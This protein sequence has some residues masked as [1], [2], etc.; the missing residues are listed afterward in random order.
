MYAHVNTPPKPPSEN[1]SN[2]GTRY[3]AICL[4]A[5]AKD[6][7]ER[8]TT[9]VEFAE[10]IRGAL[11]A[12]DPFVVP[13]MSVTQPK[14]GDC[15]ELTL[16]GGVTM[17]FTYC[18][19]GEFLMG[20]PTSE[21]DRQENELQHRVVISKG[22]WMSVSPVT[23]AQWRAVMNNTISYFKGHTHPI[24]CVSWDDTQSYS[25]ELNTQ[26]GVSVRLPTEAEWEYACRGGT[27]TP[28]YFGSQLNGTQANIDGNYPYGT[29]TKGPYLEK[30]TPV[31]AYAAKFPHPWGL[32]DVH[33]NVWEWCLDW[34]DEKY[35]SRSSTTDP[36]CDDGEQ[37]YR[38]V[39]GG[40]WH[41]IGRSCRAA[42]RVRY[43]PANR[44]FNRGF[45]LLL[46][47]HS[48]T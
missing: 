11:N 27:T 38:V 25:Q 1:R 24:E 5:L 14:P 20:S 7:N 29:T 36:R 2:L 31:G 8:F 47:V 23:Q 45:R 26:I 15:M 3:D 4:K 48:I 41:N 9:V 18:P 28:F 32:C 10:A 40:S 39:R 13:S 21:K 6:P 17:P 44:G 46:P 34:Y 42:A 19:P 30:T 33:G 37:K 35:Y 43:E 22:F 12:V 16:P